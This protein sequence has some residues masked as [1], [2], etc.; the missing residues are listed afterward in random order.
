MAHSR[1]NP[2]RD[3][4]PSPGPSASCSPLIRN[5]IATARSSAR[6]FAVQFF[7]N[8]CLIVTLTGAVC[9]DGLEDGQMVSGVGG[10]YNFVSQAHALEGARSILMAKS[11]REKG[12]EVS[13]NIVWSY[14][15]ITIPRHLRDMVITEYGI[16]DLRGKCDKDVIQSLLNISDSRFQDDLL[17]KAK[18]AKKIPDDYEIPERFRRNLPERLEEILAPFRERGLFT[19]FPFGTDFTPEELVL[20]KAL[21]G[22][23]ER[24]TGGSPGEPSPLEAAM[25]VDSV[26]E[27]AKPYLARMQL[28]APADEQ[29]TMMQKLVIYA[30]TSDGVT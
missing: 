16:A 20:G 1:N 13:S 28:D 14:G 29:E 11:T 19:P 12:K 7:F 24:M 18:S 10:Q 8:A 27:A 3:G 17:R 5:Q 6:I 21:R 15:H 9:S 23:K 25:A 30:L 26:P 4:I 2:S 22:L